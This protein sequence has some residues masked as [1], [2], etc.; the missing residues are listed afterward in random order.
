LIFQQ[1]VRKNNIE[2]K[3]APVP[4]RKNC[5]TQAAKIVS[6]TGT[7][8]RKGFRHL[9]FKIRQNRLATRSPTQTGT[10]TSARTLFFLEAK[11]EHL[12]VLVHG[13]VLFDLN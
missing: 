6:R 4:V 11:L 5:L 1:S 13:E 10:G 8:T 3:F 12:P 7:G 9:N 2:T